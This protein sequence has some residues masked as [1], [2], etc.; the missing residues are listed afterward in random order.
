MDVNAREDILDLDV[1]GAVD[2]ILRDTY[3]GLPYLKYV[4]FTSC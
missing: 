3:K 4:F 1:E 2:P